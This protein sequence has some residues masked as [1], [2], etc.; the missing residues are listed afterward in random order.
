MMV[1]LLSACASGIFFLCKT[2]KRI[3]WR[4][5]GFLASVVLGGYV[6]GWYVLSGDHSFV[7]RLDPAFSILLSL[8]AVYGIRSLREQYRFPISRTIRIFGVMFSIVFLS[9]VGTSVLASGPDMRVVSI[10]ERNAAQFVWDNVARSERSCVIADMWPLL[11]LEGLSG[12]GIVGGGFPQDYLFAQPERTV[13]YAEMLREPRL[14]I[15]STAQDITGASSCAIM[16]P[17]SSVDQEKID[18]ITEF[19]DI[20]PEKIGDMAVWVP[21]IE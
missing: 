4:V 8:L 2:E 20:R 10:S 12:Q 11:A 13:L 6:V 7:R 15:V 1:L 18:T 5:I 16:V 19:M 14:S 3:Q 21:G 17:M 9:W